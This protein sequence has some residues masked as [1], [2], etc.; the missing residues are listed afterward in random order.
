MMGEERTGFH[1]YTRWGIEE[2]VSQ[3]VRCQ[4]HLCSELGIN[5]HFMFDFG[6]RVRYVLIVVINNIWDL[7][8]CSAVH[9][10]R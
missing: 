4:R 8:V 5:V 6:D 3:G 7:N 9:D 10:V 1:I 2:S